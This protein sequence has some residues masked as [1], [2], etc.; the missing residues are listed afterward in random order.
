VRAIGIIGHQDSGKTT[1]AQALSQE[2]RDR[3]HRVAVVK[4]STHGID[5]EGKDTAR[6]REASDQV[7][8]ISPQES[9]VLWRVARR[10]EDILSYLDAD[11]VIIEG[12]KRERTFPKI[13]CLKGEPEDRALFDGLAIAAVGPTY[14]VG[15]IPIP[16]LERGDIAAIAD[17][18]EKRAFK[19]PHLDCGACGYRTCYDMAL[20]IV[21][22]NRTIE[23]CVSLHPTTQ[24]R[25]NGRL[26]PMKPF[27]S[28][29]VRGAIV[30]ALSSLKGYSP[31]EI[32]IHMDG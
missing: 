29:L 5:L 4:H 11:I 1:L 3:G 31:G 9:L 10:L 27:I 13:V 18:V 17:L 15:D 7:A 24:V 30:G 16:V 26:L 28:R 12:F 25:I 32:E 2:L 22:G 21:A 8:F 6:L 20:E 23:D 14:Q 19:L